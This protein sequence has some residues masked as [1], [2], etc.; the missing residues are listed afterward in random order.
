[1][2]SLALRSLGLTT[3]ALDAGMSLAA[4]G[5]PDL[6]CVVTGAG[7][8][9]PGLEAACADLGAALVEAASSGEAALELGAGGP[10]PRPGGHILLTSGATGA[11]KKVLMDPAFESDFYRL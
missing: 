1:M 4:L 11:R 2:L 8:A 7:D 9:W 5:L 10:A 3:I 6:R